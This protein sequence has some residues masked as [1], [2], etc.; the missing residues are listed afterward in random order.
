MH[1]NY[2]SCIHITFF[3]YI[4]V[5]NLSA[6]FIIYAWLIWVEFTLPSP[7]ATNSQLPCKAK[8]LNSHAHWTEKLPCKV[9]TNV[10]NSD[11]QR[12]ASR[13]SMHSPG[14]HARLNPEPGIMHSHFITPIV[15]IKK[16]IYLLSIP[17]SIVA[18]AVLL[19]GIS[20]QNRHRHAVQTYMRYRH[21]QTYATHAGWYSPCTPTAATTTRVSCKL[22]AWSN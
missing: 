19:A 11:H 5:S 8:K 3:R 12:L 7:Y 18:L 13:R 22:H 9:E 17:G 4:N 20:R 21:A 16:Y 10:Y 15:N 2:S 14:F 6:E 1:I